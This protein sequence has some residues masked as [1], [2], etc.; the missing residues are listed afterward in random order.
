MSCDFRAKWSLFRRCL[1]LELNRKDLATVDEVILFRIM[2]GSQE[3][4]VDGT[5]V[6]SIVLLLLGLPEIITKRRVIE[7]YPTVVA[8]S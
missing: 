4:V 1:K 3:G 5:M 7:V 6:G 2:N 8:N